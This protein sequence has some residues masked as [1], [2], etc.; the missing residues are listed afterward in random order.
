LAGGNAIAAEMEEV[1]D[2]VTG[3]EVARV[4]DA[5]QHEVRSVPG[6]RIVDD[7]LWQQVRARQ[8]FMRFEISRDTAG[9]VLNRAHRRDFLRAVC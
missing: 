7:V 3:G 8:E 2:P 6:P 4:N 9:N 5:D 1:V